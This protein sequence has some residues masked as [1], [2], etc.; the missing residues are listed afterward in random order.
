M[1]TLPLEQSLVSFGDDVVA[2]TGSIIEGHHLENLKYKYYPTHI[3]N[4][5][6]IQNRARMMALVN[7]K[8]GARVLPASTVLPGETIDAG[9]VWG[10]G[11]P[12]TP[13]LNS[14]V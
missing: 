11:S 6:W 4:R 12:A 9:W 1:T 5:C 10:G 2:D 13:L 3:A 8:D 7:V 14:E